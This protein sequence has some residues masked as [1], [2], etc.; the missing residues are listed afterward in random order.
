MQDLVQAFRDETGVEITLD[1]GGATRGIR[2]TAKGTAHIGGS[3]RAQILKPRSMFAIDEET[4]VRMIP[5]A[6]DALVVIVN[7]SNPVDSLTLDQVRDIY[8][9]KVTNWKEVGGP[10]QPIGLLVR[11]GKISGV[12]R[13][14]REL[15]FNDYDLEFADRAE[16]LDSTGPLEKRIEQDPGAVGITGVS[17]ARRRDVKILA[18]EG[19]EPSYQNIK[20]GNYLLYRPLYLVVPLRGRDK[21]IDEFVEFALSRRGREILTSV[22]TVPYMEALGLMKKQ[23]KQWKDAKKHGLDR[24]GYGEETQ[25]TATN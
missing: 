7:P 18:L 1:G 14:I 15:I 17:S 4:G 8:L 9:G 2:D 10:D 12:G 22:G 19:I 6:W 5:V 16:V 21:N 20:E 25:K 11:K 24:W 3:C 13:T 23:R